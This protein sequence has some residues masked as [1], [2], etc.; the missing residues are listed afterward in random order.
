MDISKAND[1]I[2]ESGLPEKGAKY[3]AALIESKLPKVRAEQPK[4]EPAEEQK[5]ENP[6]K[7]DK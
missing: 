1:Y 7:S 3:L 2:I 5:D 4:P 6:K